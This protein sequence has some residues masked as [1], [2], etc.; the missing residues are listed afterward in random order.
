MMNCDRCGAPLTT[1]GE[2]KYICEYCGEE[3]EI[4]R[5]KV[6]KT[7]TPRDERPTA[8]PTESN[9]A[10]DPVANFVLGVVYFAIPL[11]GFFVFLSCR[12]KWPEKAKNGAIWGSLGFLVYV[13]IIAAKD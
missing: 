13:L 9:Q 7:P 11:V 6:E 10:N 1:Q 12:E 2:G 3:I 8:T 4:T 5:R